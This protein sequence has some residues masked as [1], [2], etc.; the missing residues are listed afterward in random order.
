MPVSSYHFL[1]GP[2]VA[3]AALAVIIVICRWVFS[4]N[5]RTVRT[6]ANAP[7]AGT[8][9]GLLEPVI[10]AATETD[11]HA[12][13]Q[14]LREAGIRSTVVEDSHGYDVLVF[15]RDAARARDLVR[16]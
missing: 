10:R 9:Y 2:L 11:T 14:R 12:L 15:A 5:A 6:T 16:S 7:A 3:V 13:Q 8:D 1:Q 4:T